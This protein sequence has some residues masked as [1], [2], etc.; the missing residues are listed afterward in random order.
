[1]ALRFGSGAHISGCKGIVDAAYQ[2]N[3]D[4]EYYMSQFLCQPEKSGVEMGI[5]Q[6]FMT[7]SPIFCI[8]LYRVPRT[9]ICKIPSSSS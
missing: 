6:T 1:M 4:L 5:N 2:R 3:S 7:L 9:L 8:L